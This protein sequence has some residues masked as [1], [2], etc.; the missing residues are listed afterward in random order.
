MYLD[1]TYYS[2]SWFVYLSQFLISFKA[3][4]KK[5]PFPYDFD[6]GFIIHK[7]SRFYYE[8]VLNSSTNKL[9]SSG[10]IYV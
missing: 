8:R 7:L 3:F 10:S 4:I 6:I 2:Q 9:Y 1:I 5:I